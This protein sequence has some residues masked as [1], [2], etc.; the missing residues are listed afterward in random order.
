MNHL[1]EYALLKK[2][3]LDF[4]N[5]DFE[6]YSGYMQFLTMEK[7]MAQN[8]ISKQ[9]KTIKVFLNAATEEKVN[10]NM[11]FKSKKFK[12]P[13]EDVA[14]IYLTKSEIEIL[15]NLDLSFDL[16]LDRV[17][18]WFIIGCSTGLRFSDLMYLKPENVDG[19]IIKVKTQKTGEM[20]SM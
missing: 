13:S 4:D 15:Y 9:I 3:I 17:R 1:K 10:S 16:R 20:V 8:T 5:I 12:A 19:E 2:I 11:I 14:K 7:Q 18:D 6:F